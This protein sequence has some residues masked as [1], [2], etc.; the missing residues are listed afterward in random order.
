M[1]SARSA[2]TIFGPTPRRTVSKRSMPITRKRFATAFEKSAATSDEMSIGRIYARRFR[3]GRSLRP[4]IAKGRRQRRKPTEPRKS[5]LAPE[6]PLVPVEVSPPTPEQP[7]PPMSDEEA[8]AHPGTVKL[9]VLDT[10]EGRPRPIKRFRVMTGVRLDNPGTVSI[11]FRKF[12]SAPC[13]VDQTGGKPADWRSLPVQLGENGVCYWKP[14]EY[15][16]GNQVD[17]KL[18]I[19]AEG[20]RPDTFGWISGEPTVHAAGIPLGARRAGSL[21]GDAAEQ[22]HARHRRDGG[23]RHAPPACRSRGHSRSRRFLRGVCQ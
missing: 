8:A 4:R 5:P 13:M 3:F 7:P 19:E 1:T 16:V 2:T 20:Y 23:D 12:P 14:A 9:V 22:R 15:P 6:R 11:Q 18:Y 21:P 10:F 17:Y